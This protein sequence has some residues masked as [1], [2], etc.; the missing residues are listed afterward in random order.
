MPIVLIMGASGGCMIWVPVIGWIAAPI[1]FLIALIMMF[2]KGKFM[3]CNECKHVFNVE[4][5][6]YKEYKEHLYSE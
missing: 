2:A 1:L 4:K 3:K 6:T 5:A